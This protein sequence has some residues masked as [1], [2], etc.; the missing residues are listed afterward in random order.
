MVTL[1]PLIIILKPNLSFLSVSSRIWI[2][3][4]KRWVTR[5]TLAFPSNKTNNVYEQILSANLNLSVWLNK[6]SWKERTGERKAS[7]DILCEL[8]CLV[9]GREVYWK[10]KETLNRPTF[11]MFWS[12]SKLLKINLTLFSLFSESRIP[13]ESTEE[14]EDSWK[15]GIDVLQLAERIAISGQTSADNNRKPFKFFTRTEP[16]HH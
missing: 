7:K 16:L 2:I 15:I 12:A 3:K 8:R 4:G 11:F 10:N 1:T 6:K 13:S 5:L 14:L 9:D